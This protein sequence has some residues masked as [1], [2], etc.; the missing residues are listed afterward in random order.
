M[1]GRRKRDGH[2]VTLIY[3]TDQVAIRAAEISAWFKAHGVTPA[4]FI[5]ITRGTEVTVRIRFYKA[6]DAEAMAREFEGARLDR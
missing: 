2:V 6:A 1:R 4:E 5:S 3:L